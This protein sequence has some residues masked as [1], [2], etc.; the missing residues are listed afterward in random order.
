MGSSS[1]EVFGWAKQ[2]E[3]MQSDVDIPMLPTVHVALRARTVSLYRGKRIH[4]Q[5]D[6][7]VPRLPLPA[8]IPPFLLC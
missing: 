2:S 8:F 7:L 1:R 4:A 3:Q 5:F 6:Y